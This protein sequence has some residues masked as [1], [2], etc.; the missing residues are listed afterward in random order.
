[1]ETDSTSSGTRGC[2]CQ[3]PL[4]SSYIISPATLNLTETRAGEHGPASCGHKWQELSFFFRDWPISA[5]ADSM[6]PR[7]KEW[8]NSRTD[9]TVLVRRHAVS[10]PTAVRGGHDRDLESR[11]LYF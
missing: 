8:G 11:S 3:A 7:Q 2:S 1:M 4:N 9:N 6:M 5:L 10:Q